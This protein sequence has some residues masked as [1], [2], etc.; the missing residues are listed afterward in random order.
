MNFIKIDGVA[1]KAPDTY[2]ITRADLDSDKSKRSQTGYLQRSRIRAGMYTISISWS[3]TVEEIAAIA[4]AL[5]PE[6]ISVTIFD[7]TSGAW[8]TLTMY[9]GDRTGELKRYWQNSEN[10]SPCSLSCNLIEY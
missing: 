3:G 7:F 2:Q 5:S 4:N 10:S 6:S 1:V 8:V 9:A